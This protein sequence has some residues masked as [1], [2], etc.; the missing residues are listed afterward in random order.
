MLKRSGWVPT[1]DLLSLAQLCEHW[2]RGRL[3]EILWE[4]ARLTPAILLE[5]NAKGW[6]YYEHGRL[7]GF[8]LGRQRR[9]FWNMEEVWGPCEGVSELDQ[10][11]THED[12][13][14]AR[15]FQKLLES[16][17][18]SILIRAPADNVFANL[19]A[20]LLRAQWY[21]GL[22]LSKRHLR[23]RQRIATPRGCK[24]R[25]FKLGE[26]HH[27]ARIHLRAFGYP[28]PAGEYRKWATAPHCKTTIALLGSQRVGFF[29]AERRPYK[30]YGDFNVA[31]DPSV[32]GRGIGSALL[33]NGL[34]DLYEMGARTAIADYQLL[35]GRAQTLYRKHGFEIARAYNYYNWEPARKRF[36]VTTSED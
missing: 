34:N 24:L 15:G 17:G 8:A 3:Y 26:E 4:Y 6:L 30:K 36:P 10:S 5:R 14:R 2:N 13:I 1:R 19:L 29:I 7:A 33:Q 20:R 27:M 11:F 23:G 21:G 25:P 9:M 12:R 31:V 18:S 28:H 22:I 32:H 35:N 16:I